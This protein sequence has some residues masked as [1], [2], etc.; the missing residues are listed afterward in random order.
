MNLAS[1]LKV[2]ELPDVSAQC[3]TLI[4][5]EKV[6]EKVGG[7]EYKCL[8]GCFSKTI[9]RLIQLS[10][11]LSPQFLALV[12]SLPPYPFTAYSTPTTLF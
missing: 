7:W 10:Y 11:T 6:G 3:S 8:C 4:K 2:K 5:C 12:S 9:I 1:M